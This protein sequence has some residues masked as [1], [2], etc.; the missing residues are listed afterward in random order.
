MVFRVVLMCAVLLLCLLGSVWAITRHYLDEMIDEMQQQTRSIA[1]T[2]VTHFEEFP[3]RNLDE[4][5][6]D[7]RKR[8]DNIGIQFEPL[9]GD[10]HHTDFTL[11]M[12]ANGKVTKVSQLVIGLGDKQ[13]LLTT[14][15]D[16]EPQT[17]IL[18]AFKNKYI[19]VL[20]GVFV[21]TMVSMV[22]FIVKLLRPLRE[23][24]DRCAKIS[25]GE[26]A[27]VELRKNSGEVLALEQTF[28]SMVASLR[29]KEVIEANLRQAQRLSA[30]GNLAAGVAHDIR[31]P[32]NAIKLLSSHT[33][34]KLSDEDAEGYA[35]KQLQVIRN[36]VNRLENIVSG[37]MSLAK[38]QQLAPTP[39]KVDDLLQECVQL[40]RKDAEARE[41]HLTAELRVGDKELVIDPKQFT[42]A[43]LNVLINAME[44]CPPNGRVRLFSRLT[45][46]T[47][48]IEVRDDGPGLSPEAAQRAFEPYYTTRATGT[49]L[50]LSI[51]RGII[52][53]HGGTIELTSVPGQGCQVLITLP[54]SSGEA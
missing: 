54:L 20:V 18:R 4:I 3:H 36:E 19:A 31:N 14:S 52:E 30:L 2:V 1:D 9:E 37:F 23:L 41:V 28:N 25:A 13:V 33:I 46:T 50:G 24:S 5:E 16:L 42:R 8:Y 39:C 51:T 38:E 11:E 21:I 44:A 35:K 34:G 47:C 27:A 49:G 43:V 26:L 32:L 48:E 53:E 45:D 10:V 40:I 6:A 15:I 29:E 22:Y 17:E 12:G 7:I